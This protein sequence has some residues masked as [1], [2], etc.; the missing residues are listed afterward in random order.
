MSFSGKVVVII[1]ASSGIGA[2]TAILFSKEGADVVMVARNEAKLNDVGNQCKKYK[3]PLIIKADITK[4]NEAK[5]AIAAAVEKF[6]RLDVLVNNAGI[7]HEGTI[8]DGNILQAYDVVMNTNLRALVHLTSLAA[9][10]LIKTKG[11]IVNISSITASSSPIVPS[12]VPY[13]V[14]K[15]GLNHF[16]RCAALELAPHGI[17]VNSVSPGPVKTEIVENSGNASFTLKD[18]MAYTPFKRMSEPEEI[19]DL[20]LFLSS[21]K[22]RSITGSDYVIDNGYLLVK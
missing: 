8:L 19:A 17:R 1:G 18:F 15:A 3:R 11:C 22:A 2:A 12:L 5:S 14:S 21:D 20:I 6:K 4:D 13:Y 16:T 10:H 7:I 9:P